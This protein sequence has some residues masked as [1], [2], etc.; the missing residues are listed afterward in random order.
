MTL[1]ELANPTAGAGQVVI[2]GKACGVDFPDVLM[3]QDKYQAKG[4]PREGTPS[5]VI[6]FGAAGE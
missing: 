4:E 3:I 2:T 5:V 6:E 1:G